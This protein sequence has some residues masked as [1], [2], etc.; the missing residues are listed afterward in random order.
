MPFVISNTP[1]KSP[2]IKLGSIFK[3]SNRGLNNIVKLFNKPLALKIDMILEKI[4]TNPPIKRIVEIL[5]VMLSAKISPKLEKEAVFLAWL[6]EVT[7][8]F[9]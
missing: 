4:T 2:C 6:K 8:E 7:E 5:L 3:I 9:V 1:V